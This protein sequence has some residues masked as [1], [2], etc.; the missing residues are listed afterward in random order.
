VTN[1]RVE[2]VATA[3]ASVSHGGDTAGTVAGLRRERYVQPDGSVVEVPTISGNAL[4]GILRDHSARLTWEALDR[5]RLSMPVFHAMWSGGSLAKAGSGHV[6][7]SQQL[8]TLRRLVPHV[9]LFG[10]AG[11]GRIIE[12]KLA[13]GKLV[14]IVA[15]TAH[16]MPAEVLTGAE[17][18]VWE[19]LQIEE[20]SRQDDAKRPALAVAL[21]GDGPA[22]LPAGTLPGLPE[23]S[24]AERSGP[25]QQMRYGVETIAAGTRL[26][27]WMALRGVTDLEVATLRQALGAW[28]ADGA[29]IG[30]RS[31]TGHGRLRLEAAG[32]VHSAPTLTVGA[33]LAPDADTALAGH[34]SG[35]R[36]AVLE[37]LGWLT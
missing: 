1:Y 2:G 30:G 8:A 6:M 7:S 9:S 16:L 33:E 22:A 19:H 36:D 35:Q 37:A 20:Y 25:A 14:P 34:L 32:W 29:H 26:H 5:P 27:W 23:E 15:E 12:G 3:L 4:R 11:G 28:T 21:A 10:A 17:R 13:V 18:S 31:A 24:E